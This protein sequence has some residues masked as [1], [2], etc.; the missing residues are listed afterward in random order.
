VD[1]GDALETLTF[2]GR[3]QEMETLSN[4][5]VQEHCQVVSILGM[6]GI[7]KSALAVRIMYNLAGHFDAVIFRSLRDVPSCEAL[8]DEC[9][10]FLSP[11]S[12]PF[13]TTLEHCLTLLVEYLNRSRT[14][15]VLDN[16]ESL[17]DEESLS[18]RFSPGFEGYERLLRRVAESTH[19]SCLL[20]TSREKPALL[21]PLEGSR[22]PVRSLRLSGLDVLT[23]E[24]LLA[25]KDLKGSARE[26]ARLIELYAGNPLALRMVTEII[27]DL[28]DLTI[29]SFLEAGTV[30]FGTITDLLDEHYARLSRLE[31]SILRWLAILREPVTF[32]EL[33]A[34]MVVRQPR[35][36]LEAVDSLQ[37]RSLIERGQRPGSFTLQSVILEY[38]TAVVI[39]AVTDEIRL[40]QLEML[41]QHGLELARCR[42]YI[43]Q[44]Q[45]RLLLLPI[46]VN[47][48]RVAQSHSKVE[49]QLV[50][51]LV[52]LR[53]LAEQAQGYGPANLMTLLRLLRGNL[54]GVDLSRLV[55]RGAYL[56]GMEMQDASLAGA[57]IQETLF[58]EALDAIWCVAISP[59]GKWWAAGSRRGEVLVWEKEG[60]ILRL[61]WQAHADITRNLAFSPDER[62]LASVSWDG[63]IKLWEIASGALLWTRWQTGGVR[64]ATFS[65]DGRLL[66]TG[67]ADACVHLRDPHNGATMM[68]LPQPLPV[69]AMAWSPDG[70]LLASADWDGVIRL[71][72]MREPQSATCVQTIAAHSSWAMELAFAPDGHT[73]VSAGMEGTVKLWEVP[74]GRLLQTFEGHTDRLYCLAWSPDGRTIASGSFDKTICL[75]DVEQRTCRA[76]LHGHTHD[77]LGLAFTPDSC[78]L[79]SGGNEGTLRVWSVSSG[80]CLHVIQGY[81]LSFHDVDWSP[82]GTHLVSGDTEKRVTIWDLSGEKPPKVLRGHHSYIMGTQWSPDGRWVASSDWDN[83]IRIWDPVTG[84]SVQTFESPTP[85]LLGLMWSPNGQQLACATFWRAVCVWDMQEHRMA[86]S[87]QACSVPTRCLAWSPDSV[88]V[89]SGDDDGNLCLW[90]AADG[91]LRLRLHGHH[92]MVGGVVWSPDG[93]RLASAGGGKDSGELFVWD[94]QCGERVCSFVGH[95]NIV[96][97]V[98]WSPGGDI[99]VSG[100]RG[101]VLRWWNVQCGECVRELRAHLG[102]IRALRISPDGQT[103]ASC[104]DD[105]TIRFWSMQRGELVRTLLHDRPYER[106][107]IT[108]IRGLNEAQKATLYLLGAIDAN[109][110]A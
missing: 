94:V 58:T 64:Y 82:D 95:S 108:G 79:L 96:T 6:G 109:P 57:L 99:L 26:K 2:Y 59:N 13:P 22:S 47:L 51:L 31:Q 35:D 20:L 73:L 87:G 63:T 107:D 105:S 16:L 42:E 72:D 53:E 24:Q 8:L 52:Q 62:T 65:P 93:T 77:V 12:G 90:E 103:L 69:F 101:G 55:L 41:I 27:V 61:S 67:G 100:D 45:E 81:A 91:R 110:D 98:D 29:A 44:T 9:L 19:Q 66:A 68:T 46:L 21:R 30:V 14:L 54:R 71:W 36:V 15:V 18:G 84:A 76:V 60:K 78:L 39:A 34:V 50:S 106:L 40:G 28:F 92:G 10:Q 56:Q 43:R 23:G 70:Q 75:W 49:E 1:W 89:A 86:W 38:M 37:R 102:T 3:E 33:Q 4:W 7:G 5:M 83:L 97:A 48:Q 104:G 25:E 17:L 80:Q 85:P 88:V 11:Q 32:E 74:S